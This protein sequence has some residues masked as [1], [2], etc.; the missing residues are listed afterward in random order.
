MFLT[1]NSTRAATAQ[2]DGTRGEWTRA[3]VKSF[4]ALLI[5]V[6]AGLPA[7]SGVTAAEMT[8]EDAWKALPKYDH[9]QDMAALLTIDRAVIQAMASPQARSACAAR[10]AGVLA[11]PDATLAARQYVCLQLRQVGTPAEVPLLADRLATPQTSEIARYALQAIPGPE[12]A[13][14]LRHALTTLD[15]PQLVG[16][17]QS[18]AARADED[19][20]P[21]LQRLAD[22][23]DKQIAAAALWA[24]GNVA[25]DQAAAFL[26]DRAQ[27]AGVPTPPE[28]AVPLLRCADA[29]AD[30]GKV[31]AARETYT[32]L[33]QAGQPA[34]VRRAALEATLRLCGDQRTAT[35][36]AWFSD[37]DP[38]R[39]RIA[40]GHLHTLPDE[41]LDCLLAQLTELPDASQAAVVE[42]A[43]SRRG[44]Q[45]LP[46]VES[47]MQSDQP[48]RKLAG[49]R[50][51]GMIGD[52]SVI[53][54]LVDLLAD[55]GE[56]SAAAQQALQNLPR[57]EV[58]AALLEA[59]NTRPAIREPVIAVLVE[60]KCYDAID[61]LIEIASLADPA[62]YTPAL[63]GLQGI[64]DP[65]KTD[66]PRLVKLL[67]RTELG[68][69]RD[70]VERTILIV[71]EKLPADADRSELVRAA[72]IGTD[73]SERP[74]YLPLF[75]RLGGAKSLETIRSAL[76]DTDPAIQ[77]A[78][79]R[80]LCNWPDATVAD[81]LLGLATDSQNRTFRVWA[82]RA[83]IRVVTLPSDRPEAETLSMLQR[84]LKL[85][86]R[87]D[88]KRLA[89]ER[90]STIRLM[91]TVTWI[92]PYL[93]DPPLCQSACEALVELAHHRF[94]RHPNMD[95]FGPI[96]EKVGRMT[97]DPAVAERAERY[98]LGL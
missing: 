37:S 86:D 77:E 80:A 43:A 21:T 72:L 82:L 8:E 53:P 14:A 20:V 73:P 47:L 66:I 41:Q 60:L 89:I 70:E 63:D 12:S 31:E 98:R 23:P 29:Q 74:K 88:E 69:H 93:D 52:A 15:G 27:Q 42:L 76:Q 10:L 55:G 78:A 39:H 90:A 68:R 87:V 18:V 40:A 65:D 2:R 11:D 17:I 30:A 83:Y 7:P 91:D 85:A 50:C 81:E 1:T 19:S 62:V 3:G 33:S 84:A 67:L 49:I 45:T 36:L 75:G 32:L 16:V 25:G 34:G 64:A 26:A 59:L 4:L 46:L 56:V 95:R 6:A 44:R 58:T 5:L 71:C 96:L 57:T 51:L 94:L 92:A 38:D 28:L 97:K 61:P 24:L 13:A 22:S 54:Q 35:V 79:V 48:Q 9:G